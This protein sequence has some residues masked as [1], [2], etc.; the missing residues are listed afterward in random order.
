M[1]TC[2]H[3]IFL[4]PVFLMLAL[5][6]VTLAVAPGA[7]GA[8]MLAVARDG[9]LLHDAPDVKAKVLW[10]YDKGLPL[11]ITGAQ[12]DW[13]KVSDFEGDGGWLL[14]ADLNKEPHM[15]VR[16][17]K[18]TGEKVKINIRKG[19]G[20]EYDVVGEAVYGAVFSTLEQRLGWVKVRHVEPG[21]QMEGWIKR[22]L[23]WGF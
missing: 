12:D 15:V 22:N 10:K 19:P 8:E 20:E 11:E 5:V 14:A 16:A 4:A 23:L 6:V 17:N 13:R 1:K 7:N 2:R 18:G 21:I 3:A 9:V